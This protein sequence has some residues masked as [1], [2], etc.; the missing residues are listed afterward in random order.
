MGLA[1]E[2]RGPRSSSSCR[3]LGASISLYSVFPLNA[4]LE[5]DFLGLALFRTQMP[6]YTGHP[7][8]PPPLFP[9]EFEYL[10]WPLMDVRRRRRGS[11]FLHRRWLLNLVAGQ[12]L[13]N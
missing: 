9:G 7:H 11:P 13:A 12:P 4:I 3:A 6:A 8:T 10:I 5:L 1:Q 2:L